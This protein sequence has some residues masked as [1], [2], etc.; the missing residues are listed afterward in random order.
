[1]KKFLIT[2]VLVLFASV[3]YSNTLEVDTVIADLNA[4]EVGKG[5]WNYAPNRTAEIGITC[6][7]T[8]APWILKVSAID[9]GTFKK[10]NLRFKVYYIGAS[11]G[12]P[13]N[14]ENNTI[15]YLSPEFSGYESCD[16]FVSYVGSDMTI[17]LGN[18][19]PAG[20]GQVKVVLGVTVQVP[21]NGGNVAGDYLERLTFTLE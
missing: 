2:F 16:A 12:A 18:E 5:G 11:R 1:M 4:V 21:Q 13:V 15:S 20:S 8:T 17:C 3:V 10:E 9:A 7:I 6:N 19:V 14:W